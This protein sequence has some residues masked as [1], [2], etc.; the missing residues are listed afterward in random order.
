MT[1]P[2]EVRT[3][4]GF[5]AHPFAAAG[6]RPLVLGGIV[7]PHD[8]GL[9]GWSDGDALLHAITD[10]LLGAAALGDIGRH[11]P[12]DDPQWEGAAS[13]IFLREASARVRDAGWRIENVDA[14]VLAEAPRIAPHV[15]AIVAVV[16]EALGIEPD[17]VS[18]KA[19]TLEG[20]GFV[21][22]REGIGAIA[23][24]TLTRA[25]AR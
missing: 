13:R 4:I 12:P 19:T 7:I 9:V 20:M 6:A 25:P 16:A 17:R 21:G 22:R 14:S 3:G 18:I 24:A 11:F 2:G 15:T 5:D 8:R 1:L 23:V 10:A